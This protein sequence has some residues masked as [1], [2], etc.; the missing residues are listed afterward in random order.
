MLYK[1]RWLSPD[2][3]KSLH[4]LFL[5]NNFPDTPK[6][7]KEAHISIAVAK[8]FGVFFGNSLVGALVA[9]PIGQQVYFDACAD[10]HLRGKWPY[11]AIREFFIYLSSFELIISET[12]QKHVAKKLLRMGFEQQSPTMFT[13]QPNKL[14]I[15]NGKSIHF[16]NTTSSP[17]S[18]S[19]RADGCD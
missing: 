11:K 3:Y 2:N 16:K 13:C 12:T 8:I 4:K 10:P 18:S 14:R 15:L 7:Y 5:R 19:S 6:N 17:T 9:V 1:V